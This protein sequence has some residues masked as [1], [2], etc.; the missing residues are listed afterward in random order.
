MIDGEL[1]NIKPAKKNIVF[2]AGFCFA[3]EIMKIYFC[4]N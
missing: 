2:S 4:I 1:L 3:I